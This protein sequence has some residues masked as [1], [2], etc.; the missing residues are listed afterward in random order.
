M[1][2]A[3]LFIDE[4]MR[5]MT[6]HL[7]SYIANDAAPLFPE[8]ED[9]WKGT[10]DPPPERLAFYTLHTDEGLRAFLYDVY[11]I[12]YPGL[13]IAANH[14]WSLLIAPRVYRCTLQGQMS[15][16]GGS[17]KQALVKTLNKFITEALATWDFDIPSLDRCGTLEA[18]F[19]QVSFSWAQQEAQVQELV[20]KYSAILN[21]EMPGQRPSPVGDVV[22]GPWKT[23]SAPAQ[24]PHPRPRPTRVR[25][26]S[27]ES[28]LA[29][30]S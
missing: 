4:H 15:G 9:G 3:L 2:I 23:A 11:W 20:T 8:F 27:S 14:I 24:R 28:N 16:A 18:Q 5:V 17:G 6:H 19:S 29:R 21:G 7:P 1:R 22:R 13:F 30:R 10:D 25:R 26:Q 12:G